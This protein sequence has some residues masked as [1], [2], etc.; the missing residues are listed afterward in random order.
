MPTPDFE[1]SGFDSAGITLLCESKNTE[2]GRAPRWKYIELI[3][4]GSLYAR[5][6]YGQGKSLVVLKDEMGNS[7]KEMALDHEIC[8]FKAAESADKFVVF[9][10]DGVLR[11]YSTN[12]G[13]LAQCDLSTRVED[14]SHVR[15][16]DISPEG[17]F[18]VYTCVDR[19]YLIDSNFE[20]IRNWRVP[21][22]N[23]WQRGT[24]RQS[25]VPGAKRQRDCAILGLSSGATNEEIKRAF[26]CL[27]KK[28]HPD[29]NRSDPNALVKTR[30]I[31]HAYH[32]LTHDDP[33]TVFAGFDDAEYY[34]KLIDKI[35]IQLPDQFVEVEIGM[36]GPAEDWVYA[37]HVG[38]NAETVYLGCY[39]G[40]VHKITNDGSVFEFFDCHDVISSIKERGRFLCIET[41]EKLFILED[42]RTPEIVNKRKTTRLRWA[43]CGF[44]LWGTKEIR[45]FADTGAEIGGM[46]FK[47]SIRDVHWNNRSLVVV[48]ASKV[49]SFEIQ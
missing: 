16:L 24:F 3:E 12:K 15:C 47:K 30:E 25:A 48:T 34:Y 2:K 38:P 45:L 11:F 43:R 44:M 27:I 8:R 37:T 26:R 36:G 13:C 18:S 40:K 22:L 19:A 32:A 23:G 9:S 14:V 28:H 7:L 42:D 35:K 49:Y 20:H 33:A 21:I 1:L 10:V 39:S 41:D 4:T 31:I 5:S 29:L 6:Y 46:C 17:Q